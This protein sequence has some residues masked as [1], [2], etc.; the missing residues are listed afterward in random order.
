[1]PRDWEQTFSGWVGAE[2]TVEE[3]KAQTTLTRV[4]DALRTSAALREHSYEVYPKGSYP[5]RT[6]VVRDSDIDIAVELTGLRTHEFS[7]QAQGLGLSDFGLTPYSGGY[8]VGQF[9]NDVE[10][11]LRTAFGTQLVTRG[12]KAVRIDATTSTLPADV[13]P[14]QRLIAHQSLTG[15]PRQGVKIWPDRGIAIANYPKQHLQEGLSKNQQTTKRYKRSVRILKRLENEM[16]A[17]RVVEIVPSYL[18]ESLVWNCQ[19]STFS[20]VAWKTTIRSI[21]IE[22]YNATKSD[23]AAKA[24][25]EANNIKY[26]FH[27]N[28]KWTRLQANE[29]LQKAWAYVGYT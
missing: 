23:D 26:L 15:T 19:N 9:K 24:L 13:V 18:I 7:H 20:G 1:M 3:S 14:C 4:K 6:N 2:G 17:Q 16:V 8:S 10:A 12:N 28:Q 5:N 25:V 22:S 29:F 27:A 11:A 21:I